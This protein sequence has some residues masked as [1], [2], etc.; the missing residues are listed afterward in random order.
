MATRTPTTGTSSSGIPRTTTSTRQVNPRPCRPPACDV[1]EQVFPD[2]SQSRCSAPA[3]FGELP[4]IQGGETYPQF[5][6]AISE[7]SCKFPTISAVFRKI[8]FQFFSFRIFFS[9]TIEV[10]GELT[11]RIS[12]NVSPRISGALFTIFVANFPNFAK[13][14]EFRHYLA[15]SWPPFFFLGFHPIFAGK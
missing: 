8:V 13:F 3:E 7:I 5:F 4:R 9:H 1:A 6:S 10:M 15:I 12:L 11:S 2:P 14:C